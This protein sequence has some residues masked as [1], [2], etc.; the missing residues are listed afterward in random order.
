[1]PT[2]R[3]FILV[4]L[5]YQWPIVQLDISNA[6]L[7]GALS[8]TVFMKQ[9]SGFVDNT[10]PHYVC[11]LKKAIY[12]LKQSPR[13]WYATLSQHLYQFGFKVSAADP[14]LLVYHSG[15]I[16]LYILIYVDDILLT[17]NDQVNIDKLLDSLQGQFSMRNLGKLSQFLGIHVSSQKYGLHLSQTAYAKQILDKAGMANSKP[18]ATPSVYKASVT[19]TA[20]VEF[21]NPQLYRQ[22]AGSLQYLTLTRPDI[23]FAVQQV[24]QYM[25]KPLVSHFDALKRL[26]RYIQG[27]INQGLPLY[28]DELKLQSYTDSDWA[29]DSKDRKSVTGYCNFLGKSLI[30][31]QAKKQSI[32]A[33]SSTEAEYRALATTASEVIWLRRLLADFRISSPQPTVI[34]CD[35]TSAIALANNPVFHA[36]TKH[37]EVDCHFIRE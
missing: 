28:K 34:F 37:I 8:E 1:M 17:G 32:V 15:S 18:V 33:R 31:W 3:V 20:E 11:R 10:H 29:G 19:T 12:G 23:T 30:S 5:H 13:Q 24:C 35:N 7:H 21:E 4:A 36:R 27:T 14:S 22:I 2:V 26:L 16:S 25:H 6:F 9:P